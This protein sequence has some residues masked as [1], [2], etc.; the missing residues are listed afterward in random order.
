MVI[1]GDAETGPCAL[2]M[3]TVSPTKWNYNGNVTQI[4]YNNTAMN[5]QSPTSPGP[6]YRKLIIFQANNIFLFSVIVVTVISVVDL[7]QY[8]QCGR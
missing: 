2:I 7:V 6:R 5:S 8:P 4:N 3:E 1:N